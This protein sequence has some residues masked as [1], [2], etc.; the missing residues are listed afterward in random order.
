[1][2][3]WKN[4]GYNADVVIE[5]EHVDLPHDII[6]PGESAIE[7]PNDINENELLKI[8]ETFVNAYAE[9]IVIPLGKRFS[10]RKAGRKTVKNLFG[11]C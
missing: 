9:S 2:Y 11:K 4:V 7:Q 8:R 1:M 6:P 10:L 3:Q 5:G